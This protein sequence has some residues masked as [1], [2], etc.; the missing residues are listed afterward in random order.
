VVR[1][2]D[3]R[4]DE[5][6][7]SEKYGYV[8]FAI[9]QSKYDAFRTELEGLVNSRFLIT[10]ISSHN[11]LS[12][13]V[14]IEEQQ[15]QADKMLSDYKTERQRI[16]NVHTNDV[17]SL[18]SK[19]DTKTQELGILRAETSTPQ[20]LIQ[21]QSLSDE[22]SSL[23]QQLVKENSLYTTQLNNMDVSIKNTQDWQKAIQTQDKILLD[24]V[25]TVTGTISIQWISL[26]DTIR[27]YLPGYWIPTIFAVLSFISFLSDRRRFGVL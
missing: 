22:L 20:I 6:S 9:P 10:N 11:L 5:Q 8:S 24:N 19:I 16:V 13:K 1:G 18:Q 25:A 7:S 15:K 26:W 14:S 23:K 3:G 17:K 12:Q 2:Y 21:I 4:V 27:V